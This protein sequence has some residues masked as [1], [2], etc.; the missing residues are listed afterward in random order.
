MLPCTKGQD[1]P[2]HRHHMHLPVSLGYWVQLAAT[3]GFLNKKGISK[4]HIFYFLQH[5]RPI[6]K[7]VRITDYTWKNLHHGG[8][9]ALMAAWPAAW[10]L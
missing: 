10:A 2:T 8:L 3:L 1:F 4:G 5:G 6:S 7:S 9:G